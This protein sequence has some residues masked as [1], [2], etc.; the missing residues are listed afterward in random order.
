M[1]INQSNKGLKLQNF[2]QQGLKI[3]INKIQHQGLIKQCQK[4]KAAKVRKSKR[5]KGLQDSSPIASIKRILA[6][7]V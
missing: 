7:R 3:K 2:L 1:K 5:A 6:L 4:K